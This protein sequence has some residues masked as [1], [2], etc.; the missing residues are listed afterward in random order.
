MGR[1]IKYD[2]EDLLLVAQG[3]ATPKEMCDKYNVPYQTFMCAL[4][5]S[6]LYIKKHKLK[7]ITPYGNKIV[8]SFRA[9]ADE[10]NCSEQTIRNYLKGKKIKLFE[11][12]EIK[13]EEIVP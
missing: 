6:G 7:I 3:K 5:R 10:L 13:I 9:C 4:N 1:R 2:K 8:Y 11:E 12:L